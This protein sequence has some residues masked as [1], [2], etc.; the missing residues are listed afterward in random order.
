[1]KDARVV[2]QQKAKSWQANLDT[3]TKELQREIL[4]NQAASG[5]QKSPTDEILLKQKQLHEYR[6]ALNA[7][8][9]QEDKKMTGEVIADVNAYLRRY[10]KEKGY[11]IIIA[12]TEYG[13]LAYA[14]EGL[15]IT[16]EILEGLNQEYLGSKK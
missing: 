12:A 16:D 2:Y 7:Q 14:E 6:N 8:A 1:M 3:L 4:K 15:D 5:K 13:N 9:E 11:K 10:G